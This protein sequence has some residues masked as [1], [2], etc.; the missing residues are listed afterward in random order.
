MHTH[1][2]RGRRSPHSYNRRHHIQ[3]RRSARHRNWHQNQERIREVRGITSIFPLY[4]FF[5]FDLEEASLFQVQPRLTAAD[6]YRFVARFAIMNRILG[7]CISLGCNIT[8]R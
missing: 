1:H 7:S 6:F 8:Y 2:G 5:V 4:W 3:L